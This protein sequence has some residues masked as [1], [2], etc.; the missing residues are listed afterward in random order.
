VGI[1]CG[2]IKTGSIRPYF[3]L[4]KA[5][6]RK[7]IHSLQVPMMKD[8]KGLSKACTGRTS[9]SLTSG[10]I[11]GAERRSPLLFRDKWRAQVSRL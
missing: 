6:K 7:G 1:H 10:V 4:Q 8:I 5:Q 3:R 11:Q 9:A 2:L